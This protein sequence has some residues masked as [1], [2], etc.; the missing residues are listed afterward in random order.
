MTRVP[1]AWSVETRADPV[2]QHRH[3]ERGDGLDGLALGRL[4]IGLEQ[5]PA[6]EQAF[7]TLA[8]SY[9]G[10]GRFCRDTQTLLKH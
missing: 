10:R 2:G 4:R 8:D 7:D 5:H 9:T 6:A 1:S 3:Q